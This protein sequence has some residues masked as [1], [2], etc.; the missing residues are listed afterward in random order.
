[1]E[2][3]LATRTYPSY[4][5]YRDTRNEF[6][7]SYEASNGLTI[8]VSSEGYK[9]KADCLRSIE[10]MKGSTHSPIWWPA[11]IANAA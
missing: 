11:D 2:L 9:R 8:A 5:I 10:I 4:W 6:R 3:A 1:M 7:W